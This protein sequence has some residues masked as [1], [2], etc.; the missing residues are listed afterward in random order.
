M[1]NNGTTIAKGYVQIVPSA[2]GIQGSIASALNSEASSA[3]ESAGNLAGNSLA[4][5]IKGIVIA[6]GIGTAIVKGI[7]ASLN[8]GG[9]LQQSMGGI[10]TLFKDSASKVQDYAKNAYKNAGVSANEYMEQVTSFSASLLQSLDGD[11]AKAAEYANTAMEDMSD[12]ANKFG[13]DIESI[14]NAYQGFAKQNY[15]MLDNLKLGYGGTKEE[16][17]RLLEDAEKLSGQ[18]YDIS[19]LSDVYQAI[20]VI[21]EDL[22]V[23]GTTAKE[24]ATT[25]TGSFGMMKAAA[26]DFLASLTGV[27]DE[28]GNAILN[29]EESLTNLI[30]SV[31]TFVTGN[32]VPMVANIVTAFP[33]TIVDMWL[34]HGDEA[35]QSAVDWLTKM[36]QGFVLGMPNLLAQALPMIVQFTAK[37]RENAGQLITAGLEMLKSL[38][39]GFAN[40]LPVLIQ[41]IP[42]VITNICGIINDNAPKILS[43]GIQIIGTLIMGIIQAIPT[44][45]ASIPQIVQAIVSVI[46][47][48]GWNTLGS[49]IVQW[50]GSGISALAS[51]PSQ[52]FSGIVDIA[53]STLTAGGSWYEVG[54]NVIRG[55]VGGLKANVSAIVD[56][57]KSIASSALDTVKDFLGIHSPSRVFADEIGAFIPSGIAMGITANA[58]DLQNAMT[59]VS[60]LALAQGQIG[61]SASDI[62]SSVSV[63]GTPTNTNS[64]TGQI[65]GLLQGILNKDSGV[66]ID[67]NEITDQ[68]QKKITARTS[69]RNAFAGG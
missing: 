14:Q 48:G 53:K 45:V 51:L 6:A 28:E 46:T 21:Q 47:A 32:L 39:Q 11:T 69:A 34:E 54:A 33:K 8:E 26:Q 15:T 30:S 56:T 67:G 35:T 68:I 40:S 44:L 17:E 43:T 52:I 60:E 24:A 19:N 7:S 18:K 36:A 62:S 27:S 59:E 29:I 12:N 37:L 3:G 42:Q 5:K 16:M 58:S 22:G 61:L 57:M 4:S 1:A 66:Y 25:F 20:H 13:T 31:G 55:I 63:N 10:E 65:I 9:A 50:L 38:A 49:N 41:N 23:T 2:K 64:G